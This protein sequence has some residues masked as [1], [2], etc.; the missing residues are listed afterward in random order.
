MGQKWKN[1]FRIL[2]PEEALYL[3]DLAVAEVYY[4]NVALSME[5]MFTLAVQ[6]GMAWEHYFVYSYLSRAGY[7]VVRHRCFS[8]SDVF[9]QESVPQLITFT[10]AP[11]TSNSSSVMEVAPSD[12]HVPSCTSSQ[13]IYPCPESKSSAGDTS[14]DKLEAN[15]AETS[16]IRE[17]DWPTDTTSLMH[18]PKPQYLNWDFKKIPIPD[19][20]GYP[21]ISLKP[22]ENTFIPFPVSYTKKMLT[23]DSRT[24]DRANNY[25]TK[26]TKKN[27]FYRPENFVRTRVRNAKN[28][29]EYKQAI[30]E[31]AQSVT[32]SSGD[33]QQLK[34][35]AFEWKA[36]G[37]KLQR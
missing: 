8:G 3:V 22:M 15:A 28:W 34:N 6:Q 9:S 10:P 35:A 29:G 24:A 37:T 17:F 21:I 32:S 30:A 25:W 31:K 18:S 12:Q 36:T 1:G 7:I 33:P 11:S 27:E 4:N 23:Y 2:Y 16:P 19:N 26:S 20:H 5:Q 14:S 13:T